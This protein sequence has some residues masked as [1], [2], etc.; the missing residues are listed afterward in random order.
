ML[1]RLYIEEEIQFSVRNEVE[2]DLQLY[3]NN[4][5]VRARKVYSS[6]LEQKV[7]LVQICS[8]VG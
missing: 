1:P 8:P 7:I 5:A 3:K 2:T 6:F 4:Q